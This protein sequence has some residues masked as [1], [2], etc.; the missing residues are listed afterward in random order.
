MTVS[1]F[2]VI[3]GKSGIHRG[4]FPGWLQTGFSGPFICLYGWVVC[5]PTPSSSAYVFLFIW[6]HNSSFF[7]CQ[8][9]ETFPGGSKPNCTAPRGF[10][11]WIP[12]MW[13]WCVQAKPVMETHP[14][15]VIVAKNS[16][17]CVQLQSFCKCPWCPSLSS[18]KAKKEVRCVGEVTMLM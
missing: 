15:P 14:N 9:I 7:T 4:T 2:T 1:D 6:V 18:E 17:E 3:C 16:P 11:Y 5:F 13:I 12:S 10:F 8:S